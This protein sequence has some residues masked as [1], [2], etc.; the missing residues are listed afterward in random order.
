MSLR[1]TTAGDDRLNDGPHK[2]GVPV[3][4]NPA[5]LKDSGSLPV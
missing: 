4:L 2:L 3:G 1:L 5:M